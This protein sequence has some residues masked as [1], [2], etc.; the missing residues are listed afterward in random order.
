M[1]ISAETV[2]E[3]NNE[4]TIEVLYNSYRY[5]PGDDL[6]LEGRMKPEYNTSGRLEL[7]Q[8]FTSVDGGESWFLEMEVFYTYNN[9]GQLIN[10]IEWSYSYTT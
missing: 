4:G 3:F 7:V 2:T 5:E 1:F 9:P 8:Y 6:V 10:I